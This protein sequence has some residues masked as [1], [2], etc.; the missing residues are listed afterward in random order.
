MPD[1]GTLRQ[2]A[3]VTAW[4]KPVRPS[5]PFGGNTAQLSDGGRKPL[6]SGRCQQG[7][8][9]PPRGRD[10]SWPGWRPADFLTFFP[11]WVP[12]HTDAPAAPAVHRLKLS[13]LSSD[14][15]FDEFRRI[16]F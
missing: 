13:S 2:L 16:S 12:E 11:I 3:S 10:T 15:Y 7:S 9:S 14:P 1:T 6:E 5:R 8:N 4:V